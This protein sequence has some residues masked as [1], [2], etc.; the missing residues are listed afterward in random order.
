MNAALT[1]SVLTVFYM[2]G[3]GVDAVL[4]D[5]PVIGAVEEASPAEPPAPATA[6]RSSPSTATVSRPGRR[7]STRSWSGRTR[8]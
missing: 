3:F 2:I 5:R 8:R 7:P 4:Y 1:I 6:T